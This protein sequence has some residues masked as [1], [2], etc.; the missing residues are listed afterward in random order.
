MDRVV[1]ALLV[2]SGELRRGA[3]RLDDAEI[4]R[5]LLDDGNV[6]VRPESTSI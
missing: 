2:G 6:G 5:R 3:L 1:A 4:E